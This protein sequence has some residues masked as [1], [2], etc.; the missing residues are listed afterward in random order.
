MA[1]SS[2]SPD[3]AINIA[4][5]REAKVQRV[6]IWTGPIML[7]LF[8]VSFWLAGF[9]PPHRPSAASD[10]I[11]GLYNAHP[12]MIRVNLVITMAACALWVPWGVAIAGQIR[13]IPGGKALATTQMLSC[14]LF[15]LEFICPVGIWMATAFRSDDRPVDVT[16]AL[17]DVGWILF[18]LVIWSVEVQMFCIA[19]A[20]LM[21]TQPDPIL[22]RW[23]GYLSIWAAILIIPAGLILFFKTGPW[24]WNGIVGFFIPLTGLVAWLLSMTWTV[25]KAL[26]Q[27]IAEGTGPE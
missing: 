7:V 2:I 3:S 6:L 12:T 14:T 23:V 21:D 9:L 11:A 18:V 20:V 22:P 5:V 8:L 1:L 16:R 26:T 15:S 10:Q 4:A 19:A 27:Q 24:A 17:N 25:H 13:R